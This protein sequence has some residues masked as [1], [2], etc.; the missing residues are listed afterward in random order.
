M[1]KVLAFSKKLLKE[2]I[3]K[4]SIVVDATAGNGN[5]TLFLAKTPAKKIFAFD[6]QNQA[7]TNTNDLLERNNLVDKCE[8]ILDSHENFDKYIE[9]N[10]QAVV[11][12]LGYLPNADHT[13]T[14]QAETTLNTINKFITRLNVGGRIVIVVYWGHENGKVE[15]EALLNELSQLDQ[16]EIEV[17]VYQFINQKNNAPFIIALEKRKDILCEK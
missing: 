7:I 6:V 12:N 16:K 15:K 10:I 1:D 11:F 17:L 5:D 3:D 14:T 2:V 8:V 13:I 4:N 9:E